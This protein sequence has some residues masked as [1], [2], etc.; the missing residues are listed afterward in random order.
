MNLDVQIQCMQS[1]EF[2]TGCVI[3]INNE[4]N[5]SAQRHRDMVSPDAINCRAWRVSAFYVELFAV[6]N[7]HVEQAI[8]WNQA[9]P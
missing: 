9:S 2:L 4:K 5:T 8:H 1:S 6:A 7:G 3:E